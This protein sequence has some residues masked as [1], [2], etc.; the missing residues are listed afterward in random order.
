[1]K[2]DNLNNDF[3][4]VNLPVEAQDPEIKA[5]DFT[6]QQADGSIH[7]QKFQT[8]P[9]TFLKDSLKRFRKNKSS[10]VATYILGALVLLSIFVP[11]FDKNDVKNAADMSYNNLQPKLFDSGFGWWDGTKHISDCP[12][13]A[14]TGRPDPEIYLEGGVTNLTTPTERYTNTINKYGKEGYVQVGYYSTARRKEAWLSTFD[15]KNLH[16]DNY[17]KLDLSNVTLT[18]TKFDTVNLEKLTRYEGNRQKKYSLPENFDLGEISLDFVFVTAEKEFVIPVIE[19]KTVH[20]IGLDPSIYDDTEPVVINDTI[21]NDEYIKSLPDDQ[22]YALD[23]FYFRFTVKRG[24]EPAKYDNVCSLIRALTITPTFIAEKADN[25]KIVKYFSEE[26]DS[27]GLGGIS[28][29]NPMQMLYR[30]SSYVTSSTA[31]R[32]AGYWGVGDEINYVRRVYLGRTLFADFDYDTYLATLGPR[33]WDVDNSDFRHYKQKGWVKYNYPFKKEYDSSTGKFYWKLDTNPAHG[34]IPFSFTAKGKKECPVLE[35][36]DESKLIIDQVAEGGDRFWKINIKVL[37]YRYKDESLTKMPKFLF[38]TDKNGRDMFKYVFDGLKN[39][40]LLGVITFAVCFLFGLLWGSISGY[41][42]GAVDLVMERITD[43]LSGIPWIVVM[44]LIILKAGE[45][46]FGVFAL[47]L[48]LTGWIGTAST[49]RTQFYRFRGREYVLASRTLGASD[50]RLIARHILPNSLGTIITGAVLMIPSVIFSEATISYLGLG[51][52]NLSSLGVILS[53]NQSEL[54]NHPYQLIFPSVVI[55][56]VM[57][58]FNLFGNGLR[59]AIN[60]SLK[61]EDE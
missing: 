7:E 40:L 47:A 29:T 55:A 31:I 52:K 26:T 19:A 9:T 37:Y 43:I 33:M 48:C 45:S 24:S 27:R 12:I 59:D 10:V 46:S 21:L 15:T 32:N 39:S 34:Y 57:I 50:A 8:K 49:T 25:E 1:M 22:K 20:N 13:D 41:F 36:I 53:N 2:K 61:G 60:P 5:E 14:A 54:T 17:F 28:F 58:S 44:T 18:V 51:F 3:D 30:Q 6:L 38:G 56:L 35:S 42:G 16:P 23:D 11:I 4:L